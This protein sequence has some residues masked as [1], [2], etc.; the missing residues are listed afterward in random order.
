MLGRTNITTVKG[1][2][3][4][5]D[6]DS[7]VWNNAATLNINSAFKKAFFGNNTLVAV[8]KSGSVIYTKDGENWEKAELNMDVE[9]HISDGIWDGHRFVFVGSHSTDMEN[10]CNALIVI[11]VDF[12]SYEIMRDCTGSEYEE[13]GRNDNWILSKIYCGKMH[14][15]FLNED[16]TYTIICAAVNAPTNGT[17]FA[18]FFAK[19]SLTNLQFT[20]MIMRGGAEGNKWSYKRNLENILV[21]T[22]KNTDSFLFYIKAE[23]FYES[24]LDVYY[25]H[26]LGISSNGNDFIVL[27]EYNKNTL[28]DPLVMSDR[29]KIFECKDLLYY[30]SL[31][32]DNQTLVRVKG[33]SD[34]K[35]VI[36]SSKEDFGFIGAVYFNK[37]EIFI[38]SHQMLVVKLREQIADKTIENLIDITY[39]FSLISIIKAYEKLYIFGTNGNIM[40][41]SDEIKNESTIAVKTMS[42]VKA[43]YDAKVYTDKRCAALEERLEV[44]ENENGGSTEV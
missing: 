5:T 35:E 40:V 16:A 36:V 18:V 26:K 1:G 43:L 2:T 12:Q 41:S 9:Y 3:I 30:R 22:A 39:D 34:S 17:E 42:A 23:S 31:T 11:T 25:I 8:T 21:E 10:R 44:L 24:N 32:E 4:V 20:K 28:T 15:I 6:I 7:L 37:C 33:Y 27:K 13:G 38:N 14:A 29:F 19:G